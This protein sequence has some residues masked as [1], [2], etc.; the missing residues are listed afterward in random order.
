MVSNHNTVNAKL[1]QKCEYHYLEKKCQKGQE[2]KI[3]KGDML[4]QEEMRGDSE[5][6]GRKRRI[7]DRIKG[8][9]KTRE[10]EC[11]EEEKREERI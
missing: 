2:R 4:G 5:A 10:K 9:K 6:F 7:G 3:R 1:D 11:E 8:E